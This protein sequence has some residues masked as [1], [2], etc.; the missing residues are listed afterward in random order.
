MEKEFKTGK[1]L[2]YNQLAEY[3]SISPTTLRIWVSAKKI[4]YIK[5]NGAVRFSVN[6]IDQW[7]ESQVIDA[8]GRK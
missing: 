1:L 2:N 8:K 6:K 7:L 4:P 3:L 5:V